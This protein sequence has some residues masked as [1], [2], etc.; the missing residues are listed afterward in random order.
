[1]LDNKL[2]CNENTNVLIEFNSDI[3]IYITRVYRKRCLFRVIKQ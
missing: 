2:N 1:M 3:Y